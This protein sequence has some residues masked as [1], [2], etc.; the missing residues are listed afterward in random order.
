[1]ENFEQGKTIRH[2]IK[3]AML[4][5]CYY[6]GSY[7]I[8]AFQYAGAGT[9]FIMHKVVDS[10]T[11]SLATQLTITARFL[12]RIITRL[13]RRADFITMDEVGDR[14]VR[15]NPTARQRRF[16]A[17]TF[18]DGFR[19]NLTLSL[20]ILRRHG[21][22]A[23]IYVPSGAPDRNLDPWPWRLDRALRENS[24]LLLDRP[25]LPRRLPLGTWEEKRAAF[26]G[27]T[28]YVHRNIPANRE[29]A[30]TLLPTARVSDES[31]IAEQFAS[32]DE[33]RELASDPL[34]TI[35]GHGV[36]HASLRHLEEQDA[37]AEISNGKARLTAQLGVPISH[38]A[39][40]YGDVSNFGPREIALAARAGFVT[41][42]TN[43]G[44]NIFSQHRHHMMALPRCGLGGAVEAISS[45]VLE[46]SG[47]P[48][49]LGSRWRDP[50]IVT[51]QSR[52]SD[53]QRVATV[54]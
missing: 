11:E 4:Q 30:E 24:E 45:A 44:G 48:R 37:I 46:L 50:V 15:D 26:Y 21:V 17:L 23:T 31:L 14:L 35:G 6:S 41:A 27:L 32:W 39:Y 38:F 29:V 43:I 53:R 52:A 49:A 20:P 25:G 2:T 3:S 7:Q 1:M 5:V 19:D 34:I 51:E 16:I 13:R 10:K 9:I 18:D 22:P 28:R 54:S 8:I 36:S 40:P 47:A 33:L 12:D 42:V